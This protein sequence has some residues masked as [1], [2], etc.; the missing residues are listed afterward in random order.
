VA[1]RRWVPDAVLAVVLLAGVAASAVPG[2]GPPPVAV[3]ALLGAAAVVPLAWRR[4]APVAVWAVSGAV[5]AAGIA[6]RAAPG[7]V[8]LAPLVALYTVAA[9]SRRRVSVAA[10]VVSLAGVAAVGVASPHTWV[11]VGGSTVRAGGPA[12]LAVVVIACWLVGDNLRTRRAYLAE[13]R[14]KAERAEAD[15]QAELARAASAERVRIARELHD[16]IAHHVSVI[17]VQAGAARLLAETGAGASA[18]TGAG[19]GTGA[20]FGGGVGV[21]AGRVGPSWAG[22]ETTARQALAELR[23]VLGVLRHDGGPPTRAPQP[24][25]GQLGQ[26]VDQARRAGLVVQLRT[27]GE[28][29]RLAPAADLCAYRIIQE[30]LTNV[31]KHQGGA[32]TRVRLLYRAGELEIDVSSRAGTGPPPGGPAGAGHGLAG[33]RERVTLLGGQF[34]A[35]PRPGDGFAVTARIPLPETPGGEAPA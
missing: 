2:G 29:R 22:V 30:A 18:E 12:F 5:A 7:L 10:G 23:Q 6:T 9:S 3:R 33:M 8:V 35:G 31:R 25:L 19:A 15:R 16:V 17:A 11:V 28:P 1:S 26:L 20:G 13:L 24:G 27:D 4:R 14:A 34:T 21:G 32:E